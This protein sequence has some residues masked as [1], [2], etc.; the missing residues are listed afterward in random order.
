MIQKK[1]VFYV[2]SYGYGFLYFQ[3]DNVTRALVRKR[4]VNK[5]LKKKG[6]QSYNL[7]SNFVD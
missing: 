1:N 2:R 7:T 4:L 5:I 6:T 3:V